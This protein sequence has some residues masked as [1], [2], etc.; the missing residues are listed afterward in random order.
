VGEDS[1]NRALKRPSRLPDHQTTLHAPNDKTVENGEVCS[2]T[3]EGRHQMGRVT[4]Q[5]YPRYVLPFMIDRQGHG[6]DWPQNRLGLAFGDQSRKFRN[7]ISRESISATPSVADITD[8]EASA[9]YV[10]AWS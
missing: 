5:G 4:H 10:S 1:I 2:L 9:R 7:P 3:G 8:W 6:L